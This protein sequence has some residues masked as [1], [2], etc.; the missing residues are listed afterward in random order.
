MAKRRGK[1]PR[2]SRSQSVRYYVTDGIHSFFGTD[3]DDN[4]WGNA[5]DNAIIGRDGDDQ[6]VGNSMADSIHGDNGND[7]IYGASGD[8]ALFGGEGADLIS[9]DEGD[10][11][12]EG[13]SGDDAMYPG[14]GSNVIFGGPG[15]DSVF[16][17]GGNS[18]IYIEAFFESTLLSCDRITGLVIGQ[19]LIGLPDSVETFIPGVFAGKIQ[20]LSE[21]GIKAL[22][23][24]SRFPP[25]TAAAFQ[26]VNNDGVR[27]FIAFNDSYSGFTALDDGLVEVTGYRGDLLSI[28]TSALGVYA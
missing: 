12:L 15:A 17:G 7:R 23:S 24:P 5:G 22:L 4:I 21:A 27:S 13:G 1:K 11:Y 10:D 6:L 14:L 16:L 28:W 19:D 3:N 26:V 18:I 20:T 9:G 2:D 25:N 8:D